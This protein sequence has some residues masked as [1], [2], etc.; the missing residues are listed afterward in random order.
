M[1]RPI[2]SRL[3]SGLG[4]GHYHN[5]SHSSKSYSPSEQVIRDAL[6]LLGFREGKD[7]RHEAKTVVMASGKKRTYWPDFLLWGH[8]DLEIDPKFH[9][10]FKPYYYACLWRTRR[11]RQQLG[12]DTYRIKVGLKRVK[13][14]KNY[15][16]D[17]EIHEAVLI[18]L[19]LILGQL[20]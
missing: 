10:S 17:L 8:M 19:G 15:R 4:F 6:K 18:L 1:S 2:G 9:T 7:F 11:L 5:Y 16:P 12:I 3:G 14:E 13:G 20:T